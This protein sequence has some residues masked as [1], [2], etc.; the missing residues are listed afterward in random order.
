MVYAIPKCRLFSFLVEKAPPAS[1]G[2]NKDVGVLETREV[3]FGHEL[4]VA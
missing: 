3:L 4:G 2:V 1:C